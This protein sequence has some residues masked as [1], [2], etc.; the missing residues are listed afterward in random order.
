MEAVSEGGDHTLTSASVASRRAEVRRSFIGI[1]EISATGP[2]GIVSLLAYTFTLLWRRASRRRELWFP[3][4]LLFGGRA[5]CCSATDGSALLVKC[6]DQLRLKSH[7][8]DYVVLLG[9]RCVNIYGFFTEDDT[10]FMC[11]KINL[12]SNEENIRE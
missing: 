10:S 5:P 9:R 4:E 8:F 2:D 11:V 1:P 7:R 12:Y 6:L 3:S